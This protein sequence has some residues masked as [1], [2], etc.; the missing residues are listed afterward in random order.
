ML[1]AILY[2][3]GSIPAALS[4]PTGYPFIEILTQGTSSIA[5]GTTLSAAV[6]SMFICATLSVLASSSRQLWAFARDNAVPNPRFIAH[7]HQRMKIPLVAISLTALVTSLLSLINIGSATAFN[8]IVSLTVAGLFG[9]YLIPCSLLLYVR[10][11]V[12]ERLIPGPWTLGRWGIAVNAFAVAWSVIVFLFSFWP[13]NVPVTLVN[14]NWS[15]L[16]WGGVVVFAGVFWA[17]H[18]RK[19]FT[20]PVIEVSV[21]GEV[22][23][24]DK[25]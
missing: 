16:L 24:V 6:V 21:G 17:V 19:V 13:Q 22:E 8:A 4:T 14:M 15:C 1:I 10:V 12:P 2:C 7:V 11:T 9:S 23:G 5:G 20:G 25:V 18:G 3:I